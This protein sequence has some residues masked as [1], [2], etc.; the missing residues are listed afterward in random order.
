MPL[1][2]MLFAP[3]DHERKVAKVF[4]AGADAVILD[5]E[6][7]VAE[8]EKPATRAIV[9]E[10]LKRSRRCLGYVRVNSMETPHCFGDLTE[11]I[12]PWLDGI[13]LPKVE[14]ADQ[15]KTADWLIA[16]LERENK[17][18]NGEIDLIPIIETAKGHKEI[19]N[20]AMASSRVKRVAFGAGDYT[21]DLGINWSLGET[22]LEFARATCVMESRA[23]GIEP[24]IDTVFIHLNEIEAFQASAERARD[25]GF[26]GKLC[27]HPSQV[28]TANAAFTPDDLEVA[29][30][31]RVID[32]F[33]SA[34]AAGSA[35][36]QVDGYFIDY[37]IYEKAKRTLAIAEAVSSNI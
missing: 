11:V 34:E 22:E 6:D 7:A 2:T 29:Y 23:A 25:L 14:C 19:G 31:R 5:L 33:Q 36:I 1:R 16:Q 37:P 13:V 4:D 24:P 26:Q 35:S 30:A 3:G 28:P 32:A 8:A 10:A 15:I 20:I 9:V 18:P 27:I 12:G 17:I 21:L